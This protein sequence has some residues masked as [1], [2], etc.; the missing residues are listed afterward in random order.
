MVTLLCQALP[1]IGGPH[2]NDNILCLAL[3]L[4]VLCVFIHNMQDVGWE[5]KSISLL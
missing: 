4:P 1:K 3:C 2:P 5:G